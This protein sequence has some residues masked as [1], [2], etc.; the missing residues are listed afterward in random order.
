VFKSILIEQTTIGYDFGDKH[1]SYECAAISISIISLFSA[2]IPCQRSG[3]DLH[4]FRLFGTAPGPSMKSPSPIRVRLYGFCHNRSGA[5]AVEFAIVAIPFLFLVLGILQVGIYYMVQSSLNAGVVSTAATLR[6]CVVTSPLASCDS[7]LKASVVANSGGM[8]Y[9]NATL[10]V[11][12]RLLTTLDSPSIAIS[13]GTIDSV[14]ANSTVVM[15][16]RA[17]SSVFTFAPGFGSLA[18]VR[19]SAIVRLQGN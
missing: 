14:S 10:A 15:V 7:T 17:Q 8:I 12:L 11:D 1:I 2:S 18:K 6:S 5:S 16:L 9:N 13:D 19:S 3:T 4:H